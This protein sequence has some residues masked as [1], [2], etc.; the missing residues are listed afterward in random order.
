MNALTAAEPP[1]ADAIRARILTVCGVQVMT[2]CGLPLRK[3]H[4][5][6]VSRTIR[7]DMIPMQEVC[8][9]AKP[10]MKEQEREALRKLTESI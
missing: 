2:S 6:C 4:F 5:R 10:K 9:P 3:L 8:P 7:R 1:N